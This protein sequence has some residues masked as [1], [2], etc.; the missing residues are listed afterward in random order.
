M[1]IN[2]AVPPSLLA[3]RAAVCQPMGVDRLSEHWAAAVTQ[4]WKAQLIKLE[5]AEYKP[6]VERPALLQIYGTCPPFPKPEGTK[7]VACNKCLLCPYCFGRRHFA[8]A[9]TRMEQAA[10]N[11]GRTLL[12]FETKRRFRFNA[13]DWDPDQYWTVARYIRDWMKAERRLEVDAIDRHAAA[14]LHRVLV[15]P[16]EIEVTRSGCI[17]LASRSRGA[18][19][20]QKFKYA[21]LYTADDTS[22]K[23]LM[24]EMPRIMAF[25]AGN[26]L[27]ENLVPLARIVEAL[28]STRMLATY[29]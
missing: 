16:E 3:A 14:V 17:E 10:K 24:R 7:G 13:D 22:V 29:S 11:G 25:P 8:K 23:T 20:L 28:G 12:F 26:L 21:R 15:T 9:F 6:L 27:L 19:A 1:R 5:Q 2:V 18:D 4:T